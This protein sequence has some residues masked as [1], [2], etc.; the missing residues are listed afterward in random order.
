MHDLPV[1][2]VQFVVQFSQMV[3]A[4]LDLESHDGQALKGSS[5][6]MSSPSMKKAEWEASRYLFNFV[7]RNNA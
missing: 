2:A 5:C 4:A 7:M 1:L 3:A 6:V